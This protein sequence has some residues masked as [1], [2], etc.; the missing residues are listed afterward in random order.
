MLQEWSPT[1]RLLVVVAT[2]YTAYS[3]MLLLAAFA[4]AATAERYQGAAFV[5]RGKAHTDGVNNKA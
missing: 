4:A 3:N 2:Q 1:E 5:V